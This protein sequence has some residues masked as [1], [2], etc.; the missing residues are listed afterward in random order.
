[1][2]KKRVSSAKASRSRRKGKNARKAPRRSF[3]SALLGFLLKL[4]LVLSV[5]AAIGLAYLD[6][7]VREKFEG[8][9]WALPAKVY[10]RPLELYPGQALAMDDLKAELNGLGYRFVKSAS[11]PGQA[12]WAS[13]RVRVQ[14]R[15]FVFPDSNEPPRDLLLEFR[16]NS[17]SRI[18][19][20]SG[21][22]PLARLEPVL[23][24]GIY[25]TSNEDR[26]LIRL[27]E[28]PPYLVES[29]IG[30]E[31][32][33][34]YDHHGIS[35]KGIARAMWVNIQAGRFV[36]GGST[37]TQ[38]LIKNFYLTADRTL[39]RKLLEMPMAVLLELHYSK[40]E[41]LEAYLNE[42]YLGQ[43][44]ARAI[45]GFGLGSQYF[46]GRPL[47]E[48][49]LH[50][51]ALLAGMVKGPSYYDPRRHPERAR[52]RRNL[53]LSILAERGVITPQQ[54]EEAQARD[55]D[56]VKSKSLHKGAYPAY[57]D[58]VKRQLRQDYR[59]ED[60]GS[61]G[62][63]V[64]TSLDPIVHRRAET[65]M[66]ETT[67]QLVRK[68]GKKLEGLQGSMV[69]TDPQTGD[70][71]A[72]IGGRDTRYQGFN[73]ALD[74]NR[75]IGSLVK[76]AVY[77]AALEQGYTLA[78]RIEDEPVR[79][80]MPN[81]DVWAPDNFDHQAHGEV[82]LHRALAKSY[83]L[84]TARLGLDI[85]VDKVVDMLHRLGLER[86]INAYPALLLGGETMSPVEV[87]NIY[88]TLAANGFQTPL[89]AIRMV[90]DADGQ[91]LSRYPFKVRQT[92]PVELVHLIQ[93]AMQE[94]AREGTAR[95]AYS[96]LPADLNIAG[97]TGTSNNQRDSWFA[98]FTGNR[99]AVVWLGRDD[100]A[101]MPITGSSGALRVWTDFMRRE[102]PQPYLARRPD[103]IEYVWVDDATGLRSD[104]R[105]E[106]SRQLPFLVGTAPLQGVDCGYGSP[107]QR[108]VDWFRS[109]FR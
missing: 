46:F 94:V 86:D 76:P 61:E 62:L 85:G 66:V 31:D 23:V 77:L 4:T 17:L 97:K 54:L 59:E 36:Q 82:P 100:N 107:V 15:G 40:D 88:Q 96:Q 80:Q 51:V 34:F 102:H 87:A 57:L 105:C 6:M 21:N 58:L 10:A 99:L 39:A 65:A 2:T 56:V 49:Q 52:A 24:G 5:F 16:G 22:L 83:N 75:S 50:Q 37:L 73:R 38:Q 64:F 44:G 18:R 28:A 14:T 104:Q 26:D 35:L 91:E 92:V 45:H 93:Y 67:E 8:K 89:R 108:S 71:L 3:W 12:E 19:D 32:R 33:S 20:G 27:S 72:I 48:L 55:L 98:G 60:L 81:G 90:T 68:Y 43:S 95:Y 25:P 101:P 41:I 69:V 11:A 63:R 79:L 1:M 30:I 74:A 9:R 109:W 13:S 84:A 106:G 29:L 47:Q 78:S 42:V 53:V 103:D 70:A 7:Q